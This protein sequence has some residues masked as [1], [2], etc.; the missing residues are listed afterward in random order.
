[1]WRDWIGLPHRFRADPRN[2]HGADCLIM[3]WNV[4]EDAGAPHPRLDPT[5][6]D[7]AEWGRHRLLAQTYEELTM[8][9]D[10]PEEYAVTLFSTARTI[11]IGVVVDGGLLHVHH[12]RGVQWMPLDR[13]KPLEFRKFK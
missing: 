11:G 10:A 3:V 5:W 7:L 1:M 6:L 2:G 12:R 4:L 8:P 9:L 13:C